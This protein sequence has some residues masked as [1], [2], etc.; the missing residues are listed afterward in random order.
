MKHDRSLINGCDYLKDL[1]FVTDFFLLRIRI[2]S[3]EILTRNLNFGGDYLFVNEPGFRKENI[4]AF[5]AKNHS[6]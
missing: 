2:K 1:Q 6:N 3:G 5:V 4:H